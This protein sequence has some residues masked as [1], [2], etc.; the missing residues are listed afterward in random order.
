MKPREIPG[1]VSGCLLLTFLLS[2]VP[3]SGQSGGANTW[4]KPTSGNWEDPSAWSL[5][6]LPNSSQ[7]V[8]ITNS[9]WKAVAVNSS[10]PI[11]F[12]NAM[13][14]DS[15]TIRGAWDTFNTLLL[16]YAG[17]AVPLRV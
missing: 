4:T 3:V 1:V 2:L 10:T 17:T 8:L 14:V 6:V 9:G 13:T 15:L 5:G 7:S 16:N 12:P 11:N